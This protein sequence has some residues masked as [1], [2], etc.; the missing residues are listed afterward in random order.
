MAISW[1]TIKSLLIFFGPLLLPKAIGYYKSIRNA[2]RASGVPIRPVPPKV[3]RALAI[4][5]TI[6]AILLLRALPPFAPEN[7][8]TATQSRLQIPTDVLFNRLS[9]LRP[10]PAHALTPTDEA[11]RAKFVNLE[12]RLLYLQYGPA[13]LAECPFCAADDPQTYWV[14]ALPSLLAPHLLNLVTVALATSDLVA[15]PEGPRW[16]T[17]TTLVAALAAAL[18]VYAVST[19][20]AQ[21]NARATRLPDLDMFFW[22][23]RALRFAGLGLLDGVLGLLLW[24]ASTRRAFASPPSPAERVEGVT[25]ALLT[26]KGRLAAV[27]IVKNTTNRDEELRGRTQAYWL[28]EGRVMRDVMEEREVVEGVNDA[29]ANRIDIRDITRDAETYALH[30]LPRLEEEAA[31]APETTVG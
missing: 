25:R 15:G 19:Y 11:L 8:F 26:T 17:T 1:G 14:Y 28:H 16:R 31:P 30:M 23:T 3:I 10:G 7:I 29:L 13:V 18:D 27:G 21:A 6:S 20:G 2:S 12:S 5:A 22:R 4:I 24:A 9:S